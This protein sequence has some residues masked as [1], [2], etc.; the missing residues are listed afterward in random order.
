MGAPEG[1]RN[2][3]FKSGRYSRAMRAERQAAAKAKAIE[4]NRERQARAGNARAEYDRVL[5]DIDDWEARNRGHN[6]ESDDD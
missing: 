1:R 3:N 6:T 2:G 5:R 4:A